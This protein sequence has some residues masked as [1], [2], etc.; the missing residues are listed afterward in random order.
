MGN[1][2]KLCFTKA[3][4]SEIGVEHKNKNQTNGISQGLGQAHFISGAEDHAEKH[5][6]DSS[7]IGEVHVT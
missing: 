1:I 7:S 5:N 6:A 2:Y 4:I 3:F